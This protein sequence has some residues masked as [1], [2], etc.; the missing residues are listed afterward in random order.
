MR[1]YDQKSTLE[2]IGIQ[3]NRKS[4]DNHTN[5]ND[6]R[7]VDICKNDNLTILNGRYGKDKNIGNTTFRGNSVIDYT[8]SSIKG[9]SLLNDFE[10]I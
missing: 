9:F 4:Q 7:L 1:F 2:S 8:I 5:N 3:L 10:V 6:Y